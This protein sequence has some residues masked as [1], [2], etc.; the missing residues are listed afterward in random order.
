MKD[1]SQYREALGLTQ[2]EMVLLLK[3]PKSKLGMFEIGQ[4]DLPIAT[5]TQLIALY[6]LVQEPQREPDVSAEEKKKYDE[7][8]G[9]QIKKELLENE[10][11]LL[12]LERKLEQYKIKYQKYSKQKRLVNILEN[13]VNEKQ[14]F[15][16]DMIT[17]LKRKAERNLEQC[18]LLEQTKLEIKIK[19]HKS[20]Q[21][22]LENYITN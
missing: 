5:K 17:V 15:S 22:E 19:G 6:N 21:K 7:A 20:F 10:Y 8:L 12:V 11:K 4:R 16:K 9:L 18:S 1:A 14:S 13:Q 3:I 2:E